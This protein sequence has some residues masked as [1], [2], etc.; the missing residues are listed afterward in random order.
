[1]IWHDKKH[2]VWIICDNSVHTQY[3]SI[4]ER[5]KIKVKA[6]PSRKWGLE[7][8]QKESKQIKNKN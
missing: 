8:N 3:I 7:V 4:I 1:M 2:S 6:R 5:I